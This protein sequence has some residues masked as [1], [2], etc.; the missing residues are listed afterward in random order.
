MFLISQS[1]TG[2]LSSFERLKR[3]ISHVIELPVTSRSSDHNPDLKI[4]LHRGR[5]KLITYGAIYSFEDLY[6]NFRKSFERF[7]W[8]KHKID[9]CLVLGLGLGSIPDMLVNKF[10]KNIRFTAVD[11][12]EVV[13][14]MALEYVMRPKKIDID[15]FTADAASFLQWHHSRYDMICVDVFVGDKIPSD[16]QTQDALMA[17]KK[18]LNP[19]GVLLYNRLSRYQPDIDE[20]LKFLDAIFLKVFPDGGYIDLDGNWMFVNRRSDFK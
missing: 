11:I 6:S 7:F 9:S 17:M 18:M 19:N 5:Y 10:K 16:L 15:V 13:I 2:Q 8:D 14:S 12:D 1:Q 20:S 3:W 4:T